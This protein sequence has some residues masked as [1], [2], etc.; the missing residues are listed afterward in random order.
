MHLCEMTIDLKLTWSLL[1]TNV[2]LK[3]LLAALVKKNPAKLT[4]FNI[5][6]KKGL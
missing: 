1:E 2:L 3:R 4:G 6:R 5:V